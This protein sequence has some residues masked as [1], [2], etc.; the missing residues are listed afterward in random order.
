M[1]QRPQFVDKFFKDH[2]PGELRGRDLRDPQQRARTMDEFV[3]DYVLPWANQARMAEVIYES[4]DDRIRQGAPARPAEY[5]LNDHTPLFRGE[6]RA[7]AVGA[8]ENRRILMDVR[9]RVRGGFE[10]LDLNK[11]FAQVGGGRDARAVIGRLDAARKAVLSDYAFKVGDS[12]SL[13]DRLDE[14]RALASKSMDDIRRVFPSG[15]RRPAAVESLMDTLRGIERAGTSSGT[16]HHLADQASRDRTDATAHPDREPLAQWEASEHGGTAVQT[17]DHTAAPDGTLSV[18]LLTRGEG[19]VPEGLGSYRPEDW[20]RRADRI[21]VLLSTSTFR[22]HTALEQREGSRFTTKPQDVPWHDS[23]VTFFASHGASNHVELVLG[24]GR[25]VRVSGRELGRYLARNAE[26]LGDADK[27]LVLLSCTTGASPEH[28]GLSV[29][30]HVANVTGRVVHAPSTASGTVRGA[31]GRLQPVLF[32]DGQG[33]QGSWL[34]FRPEPSGASL[35]RM[36]RAAGLHTGEGVPDPWTANRTLQYVRTLRGVLGHEAEGTAEHDA[37]LAGLGALDALRWNPGTDGAPATHTAGRMNADV[38]RA[39]T[40]DVLGLPEGTEQTRE[41]WTAV[42]TAARTAHADDPTSSLSALDPRVESGPGMKSGSRVE[43]GPVTESGSRTGSDEQVPPQPHSADAPRT[44]DAPRTTGSTGHG[45]DRQV[46]EE[47]G[48]EATAVRQREPED[49]AREETASDAT[50]DLMADPGGG[51]RSS[52][53]RHESGGGHRSSHARHESA[54]PSHGGVNARSRIATQVAAFGR[55]LNRALAE[56]E[57]TLD[58]RALRDRTDELVR[59]LLGEVGPAFRSEAVWEARKLIDELPRTWSDTAVNTASRVVAAHDT[60]RSVLGEPGATYLGTNHI[61]QGPGQG[62]VN[63]DI[64]SVVTIENRPYVPIYTAVFG[65]QSG[66]REP[67]FKD[68]GQDRGGRVQI[69]TGDPKSGEKVFWL[70]VGQPL[71]QL[72]WV[73]KYARQQGATDPM[74]RSF[75]VPLEVANDISRDAVTEHGSG[76]HPLDLNVDKHFASN[77]FGITKPESLE[78]LRAY[79]LPGSLRTYAERVPQ[80]V[81]TAWGD[82]RPMGELR[83]KVGVPR[84]MLQGY[85]VFTDEGGDFLGHAHYADKTAKLRAVV[86]AHYRNRSLLEPGEILERPQFVEKFFK[87]H[88]PAE[89]RARDL[90]NSAEKARTLNKFVEDYVVPWANQAGMAEA[91]Y[92]SFDERIREGAPERPAEYTLRPQAPQFRGERR[93]EAVS[94]LENQSV[95]MDVRSRIRTGYERLD[96]NRAFAELGRH[97]TAARAAFGRLDA[98]RKAV[99]SDYDFKVGNPAALTGRLDDYR[100]RASDSLDAIREV[101]PSG[102]RRPAAI[103]SVVDGLKRIESAGTT[104][105]GTSGA[106]WDQAGGGRV[107]SHGGVNPRSRVAGEVGQFGR[108]LNRA[109]ADYHAS[110]D[111]RA[112]RHDVHGLVRGLVEQAGPLHRSEAVWEARKLVDDL[113]RTWSDTAVNTALHVLDEYDTDRPAL[114]TPGATFLGSNHITQGPGQGFIN[115]DIPAVVTI[116]HR[117]YVPIYTAVFGDQTGLA[118]PVFKDVGQDADGSVQI[119]TGDP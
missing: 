20:A 12:A 105:T 14:Y 10:H 21:P 53:S 96:L 32:A 3:N 58:R 109:L 104:R 47:G 79:A 82:V 69:H 110:G 77:Q 97:D 117:P 63:R 33:R 7:A 119:H 103:E 31:N 5:T 83:D 23:S 74:I 45:P 90:R 44:G 37:L 26:A 40:R 56:Y 73:E 61:T 89:L 101:F 65:D 8:L 111:R 52:H 114:G 42:L 50:R 78:K 19:H 13:G 81:P 28:G 68:V 116:E 54:G 17:L 112:L 18:D 98:V 67:V 64:P 102:T 30:Q 35:D 88:A 59:E 106:V 46:R 66:L 15:T 100:R 39:I 86:A 94:A 95:L 9:S 87:D 4:F 49:S 16:Q 43:S 118:A 113:P 51:H 34:T 38:L 27:P 108:R 72:K 2:A 11:A 22:G 60:D 99:L 92:D 57:S 6:R 107:G 75:L 48:G 76:G 71:R 1:L 41:H 62:F 55:R 91:I 70:S 24:D 80:R 84:S 115:R 29:A 93:G 25:V 85:A 36:A